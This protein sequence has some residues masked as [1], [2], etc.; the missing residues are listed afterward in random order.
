MS[1]VAL[2]LVMAA[3]VYAVRLSGFVL[4]EATIPPGWERTLGYVP[5][6]TLTA[7]VVA[8]LAGRSDGMP[9]GI[10]AAA[11]AAGIARLTRRAWACI[12]GGMLIYWLLR[13]VA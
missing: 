10:V 6:A 2:I 3:C 13:L 7:L 4:A 11:L 1:T 5:I 9:H 8:S 12:A